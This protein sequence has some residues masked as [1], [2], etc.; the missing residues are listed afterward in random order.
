M[1]YPSER[2][3]EKKAAESSVHPLLF[4]SRPEPD[5]SKYS[6]NLMNMIMSIECGILVILIWIVFTIQSILSLVG[7]RGGKTEGWRH[8]GPLCQSEN[9]PGQGPGRI[10]FETNLHHANVLNKLPAERYKRQC[11]QYRQLIYHK[12]TVF[13]SVSSGQNSCLKERGPI[14]GLLPN[15]PEIVAFNSKWSK[16]S[17]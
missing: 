17:F 13:F 7:T 11:C 15:C 14:S 12:I 2:Q 4:T 1:L 10:R 6:K 3:T 9:N 8:R 5:Q 16:K